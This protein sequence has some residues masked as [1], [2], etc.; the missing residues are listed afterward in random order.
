MKMADDADI[1]GDRT[2]KFE[3]DAVA[4]HSK[5]AKYRELMPV[6]RCHY[7]NAGL[8]NASHLFCDNLCAADWQYEQ[9]ARKRNGK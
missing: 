7:C 1:A 4:H 2:E 6:M 9:E 5:M 8:A 3:A